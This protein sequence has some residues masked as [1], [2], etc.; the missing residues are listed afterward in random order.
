MLRLASATIAILALSF[1]APAHAAWSVNVEGP[2]VFGDVKVIAVNQS[3]SGSALIVQCTQDNQLDIAY[4]EPAKDVPDGTSVPVQVAI[5]V[6]RSSPVMLNGV[7]ARWNDK[8]V[9]ASLS[10]RSAENIAVAKAIA[11]AKEKVSIG[12]RFESGG[13]GAI[14]VDSG[15]GAIL[16][17][18]LSQSC[19]L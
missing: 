19:K 18:A 17:R 1:L 3:P 13:K 12:Y 11:A 10:G 6:D 5:Q 15:R 4:I 7:M 9:G 2:D 8:Y 14:I 16:A